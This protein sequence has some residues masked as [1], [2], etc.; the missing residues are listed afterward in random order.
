MRGRAPGANALAEEFE[1]GFF[2]E[3]PKRTLSAQP[4][5][6]RTAVLCHLSSQRRS[7]QLWLLAIS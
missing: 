7:Q 2:Q 3:S 5:G 1:A 4:C 6:T